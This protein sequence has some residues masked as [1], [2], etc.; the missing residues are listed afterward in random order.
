MH[1]KS[2][3]S[4]SPTRIWWIL[5]S[6]KLDQLRQIG[7]APQ[8]LRSWPSSDT[9]ASLHSRYLRT[10]DASDVA[11]ETSQVAEVSRDFAGSSVGSIAS[12][13]DR[14]SIFRRQLG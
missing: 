1:W 6:L 8:L 9:A 3:R 11:K 12:P 2:L 10:D 5:K 7:L 14:L 13:S 4:K